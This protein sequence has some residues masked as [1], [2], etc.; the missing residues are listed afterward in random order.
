MV[1]RSEFVWAFLKERI[2]LELVNFSLFYF[3]LGYYRGTLTVYFFFLEKQICI[4]YLI[5]LVPKDVE[6]HNNCKIEIP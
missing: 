4:I 3:P 2:T 5:K 1:E 6:E